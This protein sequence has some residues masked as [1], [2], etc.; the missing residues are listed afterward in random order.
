MGRKESNQTKQN[1]VKEK[2]DQKNQNYVQTA[3]ASRL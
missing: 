2:K 3:L 1:N